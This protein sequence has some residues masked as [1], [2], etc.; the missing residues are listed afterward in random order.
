MN[1]ST[2]EKGASMVEILGVLAVL[3]TIAIG[4]FTGISHM[5]QKIKLTSAQTEVSDIVKAMRTQFSSFVP[6]SV[7]SEQL[8]KVGIFKNFTEGETPETVNV[9]GTEMAMEIKTDVENPYFIFSYK[10]I[11][12]SVCMD[13]LLGDW[14]NDPSSG[15]KE[16]KV[17][18]ANKTSVF[19]WEKDIRPVDPENPE[20]G[21]S[22]PLL[23]SFKDAKDAC[24]AHSNGVN[25]LTISWSYY[26]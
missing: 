6:S 9:F 15:L 8:Y 16:I 11:P 17:E 18:D 26:L 22:F 3:A 14:G 5:N 1:K 4:M 2:N 24:T 25:Q 13:L 7:T 10:D 12:S 21:N 19:Q 23:P 20:T